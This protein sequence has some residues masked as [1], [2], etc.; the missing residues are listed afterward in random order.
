MCSELSYVYP[1]TRIQSLI[2]ILAT[3]KHGA[4]PVV[5]LSARPGEQE[6]DRKIEAVQLLP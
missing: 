5:T 4:Y 3:T 6:E 1:Q 2:D